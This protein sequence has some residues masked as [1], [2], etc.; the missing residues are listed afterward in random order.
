MTRIIHRQKVAMYVLPAE[1]RA[2]EAHAPP[3]SRPDQDDALNSLPEQMPGLVWT[4]DLDL[5][6]TEAHGA[7]LNQLNWRPDEVAG[8]DLEEFFRTDDPDFPPIAAHRSALAGQALHFQFTSGE[9]AYLGVVEPWFDDEGRLAG[10]IAQAVDVTDF[11]RMQQECQRLETRTHEADK[12]QSLRTLAG[13]MAHNFNN[14]L[15]AIIGNAE[16]VAQRLPADSPIQ[17]HVREINTAAL[18]AAHL[19]GQLSTYA[20]KRTPTVQRFNLNQALEALRA[21]LQGSLWPHVVV[22]LDLADDLPD[23][24]ADAEQ[25]QRLLLSLFFNACEAIGEH[26]G[27]VCLRTQTVYFDQA[28]R[29]H[30]IIE[31]DLPEGDYVWLQVLDTGQGLDAETK[32]RIFEP[33]FSSKFTGRGLGLAA[34]LGIAQAH[35]GTIAVS[36]KPG[37]GTSFHVLLPVK[38][39]ELAGPGENSSLHSLTSSGGN[40]IIK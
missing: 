34:A 1:I 28:S 37:L 16:L 39:T 15:T 13:G 21:K 11:Q 7:A 18:H 33:F 23:V 31:E 29:L 17:E 8:L 32:A 3:W 25:V 2:Q 19:T 12:V 4:T 6:V 9:Q 27:A 22:T 35:G 38:N 40:V 36:S 5:R 14:L 10:T 24:W 30:G 20:H 26:P